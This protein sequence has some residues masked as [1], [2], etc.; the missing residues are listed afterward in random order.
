ML[1][2]HWGAGV[3]G[4]KGKGRRIEYYNPNKGAPT[5]PKEERLAAPRGVNRFQKEKR[6]REEGGPAFASGGEGGEKTVATM[7]SS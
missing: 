6:S 4:A 1:L 5:S 3:S 7:R 2:L